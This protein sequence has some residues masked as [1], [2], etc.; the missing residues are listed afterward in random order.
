MMLIQISNRRR[1]RSTRLLFLILAIA[2]SAYAA[3][4]VQNPD[5][6]PTRDRGEIRFPK[7][8]ASTTVA[9]RV[10]RGVSDRYLI[11][12]RA[13]QTM[14]ISLDSADSRMGFDVF[15]TTGLEARPVTAADELQTAWSGRLPRGDE[16]YIDVRSRGAGGAYSFHVRIETGAA[17][18]KEFRAVLQRLK[19][20]A[21]APL[22]LPAELPAAVSGG[23][24]YV[25]GSG[26]QT[27]YS[28]T[29]SS[30]PRCGANA[31]FVGFF[32]ATKG[33][34]LNEDYERVALAEGITGAYKP[35]TCGGSCSPP[36]IE[37]ERRGV[38][39]TIQL[40]IHGGD[41]RDRR[42]LIEVANSAIQSGP[43]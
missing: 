25:E 31:C 19:R 29:L 3:P 14:T 9:G 10:D 22:L 42:M 20:D 27:G 33:E 43:R 6:S 8:S 40:R 17:V 37:W 2:F 15:V 11:R 34:T 39:Y 5:E 4:S 21:G 1:R 32:S 18:A 30:S 12:A 26:D 7:G 36:Q 28:I 38:L 41:E 35:E 24:V 13:G 16:Y 23:R